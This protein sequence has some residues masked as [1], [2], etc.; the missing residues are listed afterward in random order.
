[1][2]WLRRARAAAGFLAVV[3]LLGLFVAE[4][5]FNGDLDEATVRVLLALIAALLGLDKITESL[6]LQIDIRGSE[7]AENGDENN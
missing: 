4:F 1:M 5:A 6:P 3:T 7:S 2:A